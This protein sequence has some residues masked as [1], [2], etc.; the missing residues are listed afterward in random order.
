M[1]D[2]LQILSNTTKH[3]QTHTNRIKQYQTRCPNGKMFGH[4]TMFDGVWSPNISRLSGPKHVWSCLVTTQCLMVFGRQTFLVC[5]GP[6]PV[7]S[8]STFWLIGQSYICTCTRRVLHMPTS[9]TVSPRLLAWHFCHDVAPVPN[10]GELSVNNYV[11][12]GE[13]WCC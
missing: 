7:C 11:D 8:Q 2:G 3:D 9:C 13:H 10:D 4:Q 6:E 5:P 12:F 1:F